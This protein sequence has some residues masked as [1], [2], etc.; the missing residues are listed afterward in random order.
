VAFVWW[1][2]RGEKEQFR[3]PRVFAVVSLAILILLAL[4]AAFWWWGRPN[5]DDPWL[6]AIISIPGVLAIWGLIYFGRKT[7]R[8]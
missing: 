8:K 3:V 2:M 1:G 5:H 6:L 7:K 4:A